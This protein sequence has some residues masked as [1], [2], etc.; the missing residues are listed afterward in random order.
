MAPFH[1]GRAHTRHG[2]GVRGRSTGKWNGGARGGNKA[3]QRNRNPPSF[4]TTRVE[5]NLTSDNEDSDEISRNKIGLEDISNGY[6]D[7]DEEQELNEAQ[8]K[9]YNLLLQ[10]LTATAQPQR[11][12][13]KIKETEISEYSENLENGHDLIEEPEDS[14]ASG[15]DDIINLGDEVELEGGS[16]NPVQNYKRLN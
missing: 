5:E 1:Q 2:G 16:F 15:A 11:K 12:K 13:R 4:N 10:H 3:T 7:D 9:P 8:I 14:E 6:S